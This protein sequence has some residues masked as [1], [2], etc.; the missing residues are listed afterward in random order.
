MALPK[1]RTS[2]KS[3]NERR[4][5]HGL[6]KPTLVKNPESG[7]YERPH[8]VSIHTGKYKDT[9]VIDVD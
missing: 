3:K 2:K 4:A 7:K 6:K 8:T 1:R 9:E 5:H